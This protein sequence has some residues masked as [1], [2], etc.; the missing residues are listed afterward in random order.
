[1]LADAAFYSKGIV[2][3]LQPHAS[4]S[5]VNVYILKQLD[6]TIYKIIKANGMA[7]SAYPSKPSVQRLPN[8]CKTITQRVPNSVTYGT[9]WVV[10]V[11]PSLVHE[12]ALFGA[13]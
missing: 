9:R 10:V 4:A 11:Q 8:V 12:V 3:I 1:M 7:N 13:A 6:P 2:R 5:N